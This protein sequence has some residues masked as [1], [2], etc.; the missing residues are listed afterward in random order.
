[1]SY[2]LIPCCNGSADCSAQIVGDH[3]VPLE[4]VTV[5]Q[6]SVMQVPRYNFFVRGAGDPIV[7]A[8]PDGICALRPG[9]SFDGKHE[10]S[11]PQPNLS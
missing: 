10:R 2:S 3:H 11:T 4:A 8:L 7:D 9:L 1:V 6:G 5:I